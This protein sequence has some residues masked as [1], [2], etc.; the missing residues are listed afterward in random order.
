MTISLTGQK[1]AWLTKF[2]T[3][4]PRGYT[5]L[6]VTSVPSMTGFFFFFYM[7]LEL[8]LLRFARSAPY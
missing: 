7:I 1:L 5:S 6:G 8:E 4:K 2:L 3:I